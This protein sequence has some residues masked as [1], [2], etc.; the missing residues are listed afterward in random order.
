MLLKAQEKSES[1]KVGR[2]AKKEG[3]A[4]NISTWEWVQLPSPA[5]LLIY[6]KKVNVV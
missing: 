6:L 2:S 4:G 1:I 5:S 3:I